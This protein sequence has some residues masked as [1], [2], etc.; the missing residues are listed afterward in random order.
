MQ[1]APLDD[2]ALLKALRAEFAAGGLDLFASFAAGAY[3]EHN[4]IAPRPE[5]HIPAKDASTLAVVV[6]NTREMW[7]PFI[8]HIKSSPEGAAHLALED[9]LDA[10]TRYVVQRVLAQCAPGEEADAVFAFETIEASGRCCSVHT[11]GHV[12]GLAWFDAL[13]THRSL[14]PIMG[15]WFAYR[16]VITFPGRSWAKGLPGSADGT[17]RCPCPADELERVAALQAEVFAKWGAV[18]ERESWDGLIRVSEAFEIGADYKY[19]EPQLRF[20]YSPAAADRKDVLT[21][22]TE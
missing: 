18:S 12:S 3:N 16:A 8:R 17:L 1:R 22:C 14:H 5:L 4:M 11:V 7:E 13:H 10:Y 9:T 6:G 20:H 19:F 21:Q 15:P 2:T